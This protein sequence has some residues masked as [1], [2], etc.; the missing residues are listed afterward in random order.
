MDRIE[1]IFLNLAPEPPRN[2]NPF[3]V[4]LIFLVLI[5]LLFLYLDSLPLYRGITSYIRNEKIIENLR[6]EFGK[7]SQENKEIES[8]IIEIKKNYKKRVDTVN[9]L[10]EEK[11]LS[12]LSLLTIFEESLSDRTVLIS[13]SPFSGS[14]NLS[15]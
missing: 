10:I 6:K 9:S 14:K 5:I 11:N 4:S 3:R 1:R 2:K 8:K 15:A 13:L 12:W 7:I